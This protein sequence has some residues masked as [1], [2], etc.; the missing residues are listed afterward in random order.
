MSV[1]PYPGLRPFRRDEVDV[2]FGRDRHID[3][4]LSM[5]Q[6]RQTDKWLS[7]KMG[8]RLP[9]IKDWLDQGVA[10]GRIRK[11][12]NPVSYVATPPTLFA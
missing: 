9:Q 11:L 1:T 10:E 6:E 3:T 2:F 7:E 4:M 12:K 5:L 8:V